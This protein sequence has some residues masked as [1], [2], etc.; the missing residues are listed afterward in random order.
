[1]STEKKNIYRPK[2]IDLELT[3]DSRSPFEKVERVK[4][5][6]LRP[7]K[8]EEAEEES[9]SEEEPVAEK[10]PRAK[11]TPKTKAKEEAEETENVTE[12]KPKAKR[13]KEKKEKITLQQRWEQVLA[14]WNNEKTQKILGLSLV[15]SSV[16]LAISLVSYFLHGMW[17]RTKCLMQVLCYS[18]LKQRWRTGWGKP[19][20]W[21]LTCSCTVVLELP[22][23]F[24][25]P[26]SS[27]M[28]CK[29]CYSVSCSMFLH[30][31]QNGSF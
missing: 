27:Y 16:F 29:K 14:V 22:P 19:A 13:Q 24:L 23:L 4:E 17:I 6:K 20:H 8:E 30:S 2:N 18:I 31:M 10:K 15:L 21:F 26:F 28:V 1:M 25:F 9:V 3:E 7:R 11:N 5:E 12:E